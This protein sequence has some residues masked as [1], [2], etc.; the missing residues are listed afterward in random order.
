MH[1]APENRLQAFHGHLLNAAAVEAGGEGVKAEDEAGARVQLPDRGARRVEALHLPRRR[2][3]DERPPSARRSA[4]R[5]RNVD[6]GIRGVAPDL[7]GLLGVQI[8]RVLEHARLVAGR[9]VVVHDQDPVAAHLELVLVKEAR[10]AGRERQRRAVLPEHPFAGAASAVDP[11]DAAEVPHAHVVGVGLGVV[12]ERVRERPSLHRVVTALASRDRSSSSWS[13]RCA[14]AVGRD[15]DQLVATHARAVDVAILERER[16]QRA[17]RVLDEVVRQQRD[18]DR[19]WS[20]SRRERRARFRVGRGLA[21]DLRGVVEQ[22][23]AVDGEARPVEVEL[24]IVDVV[25]DDLAV[26]VDD[27]HRGDRARA[28]ASP[29]SRS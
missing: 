29:R 17:V 12:I 7:R 5:G 25:P 27:R 16:G 6:A 2:P 15:L 14:G 9:A 19:G 22:A 11:G 20:A 10:G 28:R 26:R 18:R 21:R 3:V 8:E 23:L 13:R 1:R 4:R 24:A